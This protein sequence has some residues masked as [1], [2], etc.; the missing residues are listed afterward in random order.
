MTVNGTFQSFNYTALRLTINDGPAASTTTGRTPAPAVVEPDRVTISAGASAGAG[1]AEAEPASATT[2]GAALAT[3]PARQEP[4]SRTERRAD[5]LFGALDADQDGA[6]TEQEFTDGAIA[7]LRRAGDRRRVRGNDDDDDGDSD[8]RESRG[9]R[10]LERKLE[11]A[12]GRVDANDDGT[13]DK[14]ELTTA[15]AQVA[16][17]R[18]DRSLVPPTEPP[19]PQDPAQPT[20]S[21]TTLTFTFTYVSV[22]VQ[23]YTSLQPPRDVTPEAAKDTPTRSFEAP[24]VATGTEPA[25]A[26][27]EP[28]RA[29]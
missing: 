19:P 12:F 14:Q 25:V 16:K 1:P 27:L 6:I 29:A 4:L 11:K 23:R 10:R 5:A 24:A 20:Q 2:S 28:R 7:L 26:A 3:G 17:R 15:L 21:S 22:A 18:E 13:I 8:G 9:V